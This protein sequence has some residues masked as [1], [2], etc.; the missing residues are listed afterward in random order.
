LAPFS[1]AVLLLLEAPGLTGVRGFDGVCAAA[2][3]ASTRVA[4]AAVKYLND[5]KRS[6]LSPAWC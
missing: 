3:W 6:L 1:S 4:T 2:A 5:M